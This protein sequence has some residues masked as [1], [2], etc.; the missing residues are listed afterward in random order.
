MRETRSTDKNSKTIFFFLNE[1]NYYDIT[2][3]GKWKIRIV[4]LLVMALTEHFGYSLH[5]GVID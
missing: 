3:L 1:E 4:G 5:Y 2:K